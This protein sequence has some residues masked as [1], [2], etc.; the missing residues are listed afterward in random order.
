MSS[1]IST[2]PLEKTEKF[3]LILSATATILTCYLFSLVSVLLLLIVVTIQLIVLLALLRFGLAGLIVGVLQRHLALIGIF[4]K[5]LWLGKGVNYQ[6]PLERTD[7]PRL[8]ELL[9][10][11]AAQLSIAPPNEVLIEMNSG[12]WVRLHGFR[13]SRGRTSL[14]IGYD[15][16][17]TLNL[18][19]FEAVMAHEMSHAKLVRRGLKKWLNAGLARISR[20]S[21][22][23]TECVAPM[24][25]KNEYFIL[26]ELFQKTSDAMTGLAARLVAAYSRQD[27][28]EADRGAAELCGPDPL[29]TSLL[30]LNAVEPRLARLPWAERAGRLETEASFSQWLMEELMVPNSELEQSLNEEARDLYSTHPSL[31]DRLKALPPGGMG[32][33]DATPALSLLARPDQVAA[34][35]V[36]EIHR[37]LAVVEE[38]DFK[39]LAK[40]ARRAQGSAALSWRHV[41]GLIAGFF[42]FLFFV[43]FIGSGDNWYFLVAAFVVAGLAFG[44]FRLARYRDRFVLPVPRFAELKKAWQTPIPPDLSVR[45]KAVEADLVAAAPRN[46]YERFL[47]D[48]AHRA[49]GACE[50][51]RAHVATRLVLKIENK[52]VEGAL[53]NGIA[54]A[55]LGMAEQCIGML[56]FVRARVSLSTP[57]TTWGAAWSFLLLGDWLNAEAFLWRKHQQVPDEPTFLLLLALAQRQRGKLHSAITQAEK[58]LALVPD[59][60]EAGK[61]LCECLLDA[62]RLHAAAGVLSPLEGLAKVDD[63][64]AMLLIRLK[65]LQKDLSAAQAWADHFNQFGRATLWIQLGGM[66]EHARHDELAVGYFERAMGGG[67][68][69]EAEVGLARIANRRKEFDEARRRLLSALNTEKPPPMESLGPARLF[70][71]IINELMLAGRSRQSCRAWVVSFPTVQRRDIP[72]ALRGVRLMVFGPGKE[73]AFGYVDEILGAMQPATPPVSAATLGWSEAAGDQQPVRPVFPGVQGVL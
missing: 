29:R 11:M 8:F 53:G 25:A 21:V 61:L 68:H 14:G 73:A 56:Q 34:S 6:I 71:A 12:A 18:G 15:L 24:R 31:H 41:P 28:F 57:Q 66:F 33:S 38:K 26:G 55:S 4:V 48:E 23:L 9:E 32:S 46:G 1:P 17:A 42:S 40:A 35:L 54:S 72:E 16:L 39:M 2:G 49:L 62:G 44:A 3:F 50:Y 36:D 52:N 70:P 63:E 13:R 43:F 30:R 51:L 59:D 64:I 5:N 65:L 19:E 67:F 7:A 45:E 47:L 58:A 69:P 27:E 20:V 60:R 22:A 37:V 10:A